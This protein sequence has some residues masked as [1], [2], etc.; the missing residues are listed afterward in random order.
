VSDSIGRR[1]GAAI[2]LKLGE[3]ACNVMF[4]G[5]A[6]KKEPFRKFTIREAFAT[7]DQHFILALG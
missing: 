2:Q 5:L 6:T 1:L 4:D 7:E 3:H